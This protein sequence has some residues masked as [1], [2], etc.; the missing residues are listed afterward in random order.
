M[1]VHPRVSPS[2]V[3]ASSAMSSGAKPQVLKQYFVISESFALPNLPCKPS[4]HAGRGGFSGP[5]SSVRHSWHTGTSN[6]FGQSRCAGSVRTD[7]RLREGPRERNHR[8]GEKWGNSSEESSSPEIDRT[9][10]RFGPRN[11]KTNRMGWLLCKVNLGGW[12]GIEPPTQIFKTRVVDISKTAGDC[13]RILLRRNF[14]GGSDSQCTIKE[15]S[16]N[17]YSLCSTLKDS[18]PSPRHNQ[19]ALRAQKL[20]Q[21]LR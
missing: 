18:Y 13:D 8:Q 12:G 21:F 19:G 20:F 9:R 6:T 11:K 10:G 15:Q 4:I 7:Y 2:K 1:P 16:Q 5:T 3:L 17:Q 14:R